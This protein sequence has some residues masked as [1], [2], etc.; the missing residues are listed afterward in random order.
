MKIQVEDLS[1]YSYEGVVEGYFNIDQYSNEAK[2]K[3]YRYKELVNKI[4]KSEED[5]SEEFELRNYFKGIPQNLASE[6]IYEF[7]NIE[8]SRLNNK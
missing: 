3:L 2:E 1:G 6:I 5:E 8:I 4:S 7:K